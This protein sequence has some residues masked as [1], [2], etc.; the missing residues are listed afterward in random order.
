MYVDRNKAGER[1]N[2]G[3]VFN[4]Q[5]RWMNALREESLKTWERHIQTVVSTVAIAIMLW[6][7][8]TLVEMQKDVAVLKAQNIQAIALQTSIRNMVE[9]I[10]VLES[11]VSNVEYR[12]EHKGKD[13]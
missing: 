5:E 7:G 4:P 12:I 2:A 3:F 6:M 9:R 1:I 13:E 11:R 10:A 8:S